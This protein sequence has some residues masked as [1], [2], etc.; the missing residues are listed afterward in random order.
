M[1]R[2]VRVCVY[3]T[4]RIGDGIYVGVKKAIK[5]IV[6]TVVMMLIII[7]CAVLYLPAAII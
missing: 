3:E 7:L 6:N 2:S 4:E 5:L 1:K